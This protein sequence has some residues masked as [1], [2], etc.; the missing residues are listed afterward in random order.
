MIVLFFLK[1]RKE[2]QI[3]YV[4]FWRPMGYSRGSSQLVNREK[5]FFNTNCSDEMKEAIR[6]GLDTRQK[7]WLK[8]I[9][10]YLLQ[11]GAQLRK[12]FNIF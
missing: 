2:G 7:H 9:W 4:I 6:I 8:N 3:D 1:H 10:V 12:P 5:S 11:L